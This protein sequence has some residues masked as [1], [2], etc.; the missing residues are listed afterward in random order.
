MCVCMYRTGANAIVGWWVASC[1][2]KSR[3]LRPRA[4]PS[5]NLSCPRSRSYAKTAGPFFFLRML[6]C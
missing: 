5:I 6:F 4:A 1:Q 2:L 3:P